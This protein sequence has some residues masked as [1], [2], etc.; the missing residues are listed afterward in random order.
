MWVSSDMRYTTFNPENHEK[1]PRDF[2]NGN[3]ALMP[4]RQ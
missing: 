2:N 1:I 4:D 3:F